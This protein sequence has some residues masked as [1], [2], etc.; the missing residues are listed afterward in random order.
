MAN[1]LPALT[2]ENDLFMANRQFRRLVYFSLG[3]YK[4]SLFLT[5]IGVLWNTPASLRP[6]G[7]PGNYRGGGGL[8]LPQPDGQYFPG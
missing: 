6:G 5:L 7:C 1:T 4:V 2:V 3:V 8:S